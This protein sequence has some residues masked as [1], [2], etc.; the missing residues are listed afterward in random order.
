MNHDFYVNVASLMYPRPSRR[1]C[2]RI[3]HEDDVEVPIIT[4]ELEMF[5]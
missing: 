4:I 5:E 3:L 1:Y 2:Q